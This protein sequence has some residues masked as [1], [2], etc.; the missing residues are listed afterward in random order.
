MI[1][2]TFFPKRFGLLWQNCQ[3]T[4]FSTVYDAL[5]PEWHY[6]DFGNINQAKKSGLADSVSINSAGG[7]AQLKVALSDPG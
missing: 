6:R 1:S 4:G 3:T 2:Y 7:N 5:I